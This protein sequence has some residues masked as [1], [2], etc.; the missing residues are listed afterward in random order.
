MENLGAAP[1]EG[2]IDDVRL[3]ASVSSAASGS[4]TLGVAV[5]PRQVITDRLL[6][7]ADVIRAMQGRVQ[8][9]QDPQTEFAL[10]HESLGVSR[11]HIL[12]VHGHTILEEKRAAT[13][14]AEGPLNDCSQAS[15]RTVWNR[16]R[17][18]RVNPGT[19]SDIE[20]P[21]QLG[22]LIAAKPRVLAMTGD[23]VTAELLPEQLLVTRLTTGIEAATDTYM[24]ARDDDDKALDKLNI[25]KAAQAADEAWQQATDGYPT[26]PEIEHSTS[27]SQ[28]SDDSDDAD[29]FFDPSREPT[30]WT[31]APSAAF[32]G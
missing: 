14:S 10:L 12:R 20:G 31:A 1:T 30:Q 15:R 23:A 2:K 22:A 21:A 19:G 6:A 32:H 8:L 29:F 27:S 24:G 18:A 11:V 9:R 28:G 13:K 25:Q 5:G 26:V 16:R 4:N 7:K 3:L 17:S